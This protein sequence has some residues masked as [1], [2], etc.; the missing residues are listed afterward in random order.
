MNKTKYNKLTN[1]LFKFIIDPFSSSWQFKSLLF[2]SLLLG[3]YFTSIFSSFLIGFSNQRTII[4]ILIVII[5]EF[6]IRVRSRIKADQ[7]PSH[8]LV[9][10]NFRLG[11]TYSIV[12]EAFKLGS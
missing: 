3:F 12:L 2:L 4:S 7:L 8:W 9:I 1:K 10:D 6:I 11:A 5:L